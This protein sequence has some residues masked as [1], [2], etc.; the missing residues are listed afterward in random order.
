[1][2]KKLS[3]AILDCTEVKT[4]VCIIGAGT[5]GIFLAQ[6]LRKTGIHVVL[7]EA[8]DEVAKL[9][10]TVGQRCVQKGIRYRGAESG[11][12]FGL[13]GTSVLWGGQL[14]PLSASDMASRSNVGFDPWPIDFSDISG[15]FPRVKE[16]L[17]IP[18]TKSR[19]SRV[20]LS[21]RFSLLSKLNE[22]F[23]LRLSTMEQDAQGR[24]AKRLCH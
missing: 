20:A 3:C 24:A 11:R 22:D 5:A 12:S 18:R 23:E 1:M 8:G 10:E 6:Q 17:G 21:K 19:E 15:Y 14:I 4:K 9:P 13:G 2:I 7:L 16:L